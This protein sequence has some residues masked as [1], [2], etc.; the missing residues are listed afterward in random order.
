MSKGVGVT[1]I[2]VVFAYVLI[3]VIKHSVYPGEVARIE[4]LRID[5]K[6]AGKAR[7]EDVIGQATE[8]NQKIRSEQAY[9]KIWWADLITPDEYENVKIIEIP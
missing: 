6:K 7:S 8:W 4:Q 9:N 5:V 2:I 3:G 1:L